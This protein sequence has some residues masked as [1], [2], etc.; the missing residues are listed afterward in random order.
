MTRKML[1][2]FLFSVS[3]PSLLCFPLFFVSPG[4]SCAIQYVI[5]GRTTKVKLISI[6][7]AEKTIQRHFASA[8]GI[9]RRTCINWLRDVGAVFECTPPLSSF[10]LKSALLSLRRRSGPVAVL[11]RTSHYRSRNSDDSQSTG[12]ATLEEEQETLLHHHFLS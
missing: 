2:S 5:P 9:L 10:Q 8:T 7:A 11:V 3:C 1:F 6:P 4:T 12:W